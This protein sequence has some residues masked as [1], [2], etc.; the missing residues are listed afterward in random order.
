MS[1]VAPTPF[2][3][4][5]MQLETVAPQYSQAK[6]PTLKCGFK[7]D[8]QFLYSTFRDYLARFSQILESLDLSDSIS[9]C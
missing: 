3:S 7:K 6:P 5:L 1:V 2:D 4:Q 9:G 8:S